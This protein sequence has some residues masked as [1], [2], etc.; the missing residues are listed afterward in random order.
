[1]S[2]QAT[3]HKN[4]KT[5]NATLSP[6]AGGGGR[7]VDVVYDDESVVNP[8]GVAVIPP[9]PEIPN[10]PVK[11]VK[12]DGESVVNEQGIAIIPVPQFPVYNKSY[13]GTS[14][15]TNNLGING[16]LY[17][18]YYNRVINVVDYI[19]TTGGIKS[20]CIKTGIKF[21]ESTDIYLDCYIGDNV[22]SNF[23]GI[24]GFRDNQPYF[25]LYTRVQG[26]NVF[27]VDYMNTSTAVIATDPP[28]YNTRIMIH[29]DSNSWEWSD[30]TNSYS[31]DFTFTGSTQSGLN[32]GSVFFSGAQNNEQGKYR[33]YEYKVYKDNILVMDLIPALNNSVVCM[34]DLVTNEYFYNNASSNPFSYGG[35]PTERTIKKIMNRYVK[36]DNS[37]VKY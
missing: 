1:M 33:I 23:Q 11:D 26:R 34:Y 10:I 14:A 37:W 16:D 24:V 7:V 21:D 15:P 13:S 4:S 28:I 32:L 29:A 6:R 18:E 27:A 36:I 17:F 2:L 8:Q 5:L 25:G 3:I 30:G 35:T 20:Q 19:E 31:Q 12:C 22:F 9:Y